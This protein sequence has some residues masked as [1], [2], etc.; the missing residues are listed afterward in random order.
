MNKKF[1]II[2]AVDDR[3]GLGKDWDLAW[4]LPSDLKYFKK[5]TSQTVDS[6]KKNAVVMWRRTWESIPEKFRPLPWRLNCVL[7]RTENNSLDENVVWFNSLEECLDVLGKNEEV[8]SVFII[9]WARLYNDAI[10]N[11]DLERI[12]ITRVKWDFDCDVFFDGFS[13]DFELESRGEEMEENG[14]SFSFEVWGN[15]A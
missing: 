5:I 9:W 10:K 6:D 3:N 15:T 8:E 11:D 2:L 7:S 14:I 13:D 4:R 1:S 12:Y